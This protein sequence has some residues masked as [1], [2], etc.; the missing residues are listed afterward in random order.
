MDNS[1]NLIEKIKEKQIRPLPKLRFTLKD[2]IIWLTF[3]FCIFFGALAFS[4][5]LFAVQQLDFSLIVHMSHSWFEL[6]L[7]LVPFFWLISLLILL[8]IAIISIKNSKK[9]Y[10]FTSPSL[11]G[12]ATAL[13][14]LLGTLFFISGGARWL[15]HA[16]A[17]NISLYESI[18]D[19]KT[20]YWSMPE[21]G[22]LSGTIISIGETTL[23]LKDF[24][25]KS[26]TVAFADAD[27]FPSNQVMV[28]K[29]IKI[30]GQI[31]PMNSFK[32][33]RIRPWGGLEQKNQ[34]NKP[35]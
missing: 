12:F 6:F 29:S 20:R 35:D 14:I 15:E 30:L 3:I 11:V 13:N 25:G 31:K 4:V 18:Q 21:E 2:S 7:G 1:T 27:V 9:G 23:Q 16:F 28:G 32:A 22:H 10:K 19:K 33:D 17:V 8:V 26:W 24:K 5:I 34:K